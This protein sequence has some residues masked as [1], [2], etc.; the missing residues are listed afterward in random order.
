MSHDPEQLAAA[1]M[2][3]LPDF[4]RDRF[5]DHLVN[6]EACWREVTLARKGRELAERARELAPPGIRDDI[7]AAITAAA[8]EQQ[9]RPAVPRPRRLNLLIAAVTAVIVVSGGLIWRP[10]QSPPAATASA[11]T[12]DSAVANFRDERLPGTLVPAQDAPDLGGLGLQLV[13]AAAGDVEGTDVSVFAYR[14]ESGERLDVYRSAQPIPEADQAR[15]L[16]GEEGAWRTDVDGITVICGPA[17]HTMLLIGSDPGL[18][19]QVG[20]LLDIV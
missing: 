14:T 1:Y 16:N 9:R 5:D 15:E 6:C 20:R 13:G 17:S 3:G 19:G 18:V 11:S 12:M 8:A 7:R 4:E 2:D 10:W